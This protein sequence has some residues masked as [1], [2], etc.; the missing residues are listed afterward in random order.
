MEKYV[1]EIE[2][3]LNKVFERYKKEIV[4]PPGVLL[5]GG[6][7]SSIITTLVNNNF[8]NYFILSFGTKN[9][10]DKKF[11]EIM[12]KF[13]KKDFTWIEITDKEINE[14][15]KKV[16]EILKDKNIDSGKMQTSLALG[17]FLIFKKAHELGIKQ[18]ITGQGPDI[19]FAGYNK[20]KKMTDTEIEK[21]IVKDLPLLEID[22][23]RDSS[24]AN[25][26]NI[27]LYNPYL[28]KDFLDFSL[29]VPAKYKLV[30]GVEKYITR[31]FAKKLGIPEEIVTR[32]KKAFQYSTGIQNLVEKLI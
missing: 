5:S 3:N 1:Q 25:Y 32:P 11:I 22:G 26:F 15:I 8:Q 27:K 29:T 21:E 2:I 10:K 28:E 13:L 18:I 17:Y 4:T 30:N 7:D 14:N 6:I 20:Y 31:Q 23:K 12:C 24:M 19:T 16:Q 9:T